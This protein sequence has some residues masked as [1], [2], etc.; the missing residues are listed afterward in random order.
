MSATGVPALCPPPTLLTWQI[1][2]TLSLSYNFSITSKP[3]PGQLRFQIQGQVN[4][5]EF[6]SYL[7][8]SERV[9]PTGLWGLK[10][11]DTV[12]WGTQREPLEN[13]GKS[14]EK[15]YCLTMQGRLM[16]VRGADGHTRGSWQFAFNRQLT[17]LFDSENRRWT[18]VPP[19]GQ[20]FRVMLDNDKELTKLLVQTTN[21]D[22]KSWLQYQPMGSSSTLEGFFTM[23]RWLV[24]L[25]YRG[26]STS[27]HQAT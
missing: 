19:G 3:R 11:K 13:L 1:I 14:S 24:F 22:C 12:F 23:T 9:K 17:Y 10:L 21:G 18:V 20:Q 27:T 15:N 4:G 6:S 8:G 7:H 5:N 2:Y 25:G 16:C 26:G